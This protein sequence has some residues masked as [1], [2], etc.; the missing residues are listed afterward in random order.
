MARFKNWMIFWN[1]NFDSHNF[2]HASCQPCVRISSTNWQDHLRYMFANQDQTTAH[3]DFYQE[4]HSLGGTHVQVPGLCLMTKCHASR[5]DL[6]LLLE[7]VHE[8]ASVDC[9]FGSCEI[10]LLVKQNHSVF[11]NTRLTVWPGIFCT[12]HHI[13][14][15]ITII[16]LVIILNNMLASI[17]NII[18]AHWSS[19]PPKKR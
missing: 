15:G 7:S 12:C 1:S 3:C 5:V 2:M 10:N 9:M 16:N 6:Y 13:L 18:I 8:G 4:T 17:I 19:P 14:H 11:L